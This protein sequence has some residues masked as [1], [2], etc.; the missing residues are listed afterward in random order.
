MESDFN[1][2]N[3]DD[4]SSTEPLS[5]LAIH[6]KLSSQYVARRNVNGFV[7]ISVESGLIGGETKKKKRN[8][9]PMVSYK[10]LFHCYCRQHWRAINWWRSMP[11]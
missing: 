5:L 2:E 7:P 8:E 6:K 9:K 4:G 3:F 10:T 11:A 1:E